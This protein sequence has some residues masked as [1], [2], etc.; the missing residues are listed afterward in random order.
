MV[1]G[2]MWLWTTASPPATTSWCSPNLSERTSS[3][4][5]YWKKLMLSKQSLLKS[6]VKW[7]RAARHIFTYHVLLL[8]H[9]VWFK[10]PCIHCKTLVLSGLIFSVLFR[11]IRK[12][13]STGIK[14][15]TL[16]RKT[17]TQAVKPVTSLTLH[18]VAYFI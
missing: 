12:F 3:G 4:A 1:N 15:I 2:S 5:L 6:S 13:N 9:S 17:V 10:F 16:L 7:W 18:Y 14:L 8:V 11:E